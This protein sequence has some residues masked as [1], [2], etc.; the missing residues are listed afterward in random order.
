MNTYCVV[1]PEGF[2]V[3]RLSYNTEDTVPTP[4]PCYPDCQIILSTGVEQIGWTYVDGAFQSPPIDPNS[5]PPP[6]ESTV[7][8]APTLSDLQSQMA[9]LQAHMSTLMGASS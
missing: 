2:I 3:N 8:P 6:P 4:H 1:N 9:Q 7:A 5:P